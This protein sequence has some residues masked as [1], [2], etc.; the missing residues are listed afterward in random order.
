M[1]VY[2][3][4]R[5]DATVFIDRGFSIIKDGAKDNLWIFENKQNFEALPND[6]EYVLS[7]VLQF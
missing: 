2:V 6:T 3:K 5:A 1:F 7:D 4:N